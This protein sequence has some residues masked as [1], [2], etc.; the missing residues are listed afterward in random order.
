[1]TKKE[2]LPS[3]VYNVKAIS[4]AIG[5][6]GIADVLVGILDI[7]SQETAESI[8]DLVDEYDINN[9]VERKDLE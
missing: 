4:E 1:M 3:V 2:W 6:Y 9:G 8:L 7:V 5:T